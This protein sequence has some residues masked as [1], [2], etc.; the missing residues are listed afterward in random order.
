MHYDV[1]GDNVLVTK[2]G[3]V[4]LADFGSATQPS[5]ENAGRVQGTPYWM[6]PEVIELEDSDA[7]A[8]IWSVGCTGKAYPHPRLGALH[9]QTSLL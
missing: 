6:A 2:E 3:T 8:D 5:V 1:K 4:K 7:K 9:R